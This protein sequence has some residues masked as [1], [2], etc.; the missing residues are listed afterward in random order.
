MR[1]P[2]KWFG[3]KGHFTQ[4]LLPL[5]PPHRCYCE[6]FGGGASLL[7]AKEPSKVE[8]YNDIDGDVVSF[9]RLFHDPEAMK[10]FQRKCH[11]TPYSR[12]L[13]FEFRDSLYNEGLEPS[14]RIYRWFIVQRMA[15][16]ASTNGKKT[17]MSLSHQ[18][19]KSSQ[20]KYDIDHLD[21]Y[22][23][24][25][26]E[27]QIDNRS[28][29]VVI[30]CYDS[31]YTFFYLDPPYVHDTRLTTNAYAHEMADFQHE[32]LVEALIDVQGK[33]LLSGYPNNIYKRLERAGW[34]Y[35]D[36]ETHAYSA[37]RKGDEESEHTK[38]TERLWMNCEIQP[39][40]F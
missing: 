13:Y 8:V 26:R 27:V 20:M 34:L 16:N 2:I 35:S 14:E 11:Y 5:I 6:V 29:E 31:P 17:G 15:F 40:L 10:E 18:R 28:W 22:A 36:I 30:D 32:V 7:F 4:H 3:G 12:Q 1:S 25:L 39:A 37:L 21:M 38:R 23:E 24:R 33:V 19:A 9:F